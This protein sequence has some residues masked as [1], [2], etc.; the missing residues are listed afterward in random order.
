MGGAE[1]IERMVVTFY[2]LTLKDDVL[3]PYFE[4]M[5]RQ[6]IHYVALWFGEVFGGPAEY[7][8]IR[9]KLTAHPHVVKVHLAANITEEARVRWIQLMAKAADIEKI[10]NDPEFRQAFMAYLEWGTRMNEVFRQTPVPENSPMPKW[11]WGE[12]KPFVPPEC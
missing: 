5:T 11:G 2:N 12:R 1:A 4:H 7:S 3:R 6:H 9:G 8:K 10:T